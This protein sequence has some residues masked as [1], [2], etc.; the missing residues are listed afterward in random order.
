MLARIALRVF[1]CTLLTDSPA[2]IVLAPSDPARTAA[3]SDPLPP[4]RPSDAWRRAV[5]GLLLAL[6]LSLLLAGCAFHY[7]DPATG[8]EHVWGIGHMA[9]RATPPR[10]GYRAVVRRTDLWGVG[11]GRTGEGAYLTIGWDR[12]EQV[13]ILDEDTALRL[14]WPKGDLL[15]IRV[16]AEWPHGID[17]EIPR[18]ED[19]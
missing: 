16:G 9:M 19:R 18:T 7:F 10:E 11:V 3:V 14:E 6:P 13:E 15:R 2:Q 1:D 17:A 8:T 4:A 5:V 12:R